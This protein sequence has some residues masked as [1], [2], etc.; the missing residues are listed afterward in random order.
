V[1]EFFV[2]RAGDGDRPPILR[3]IPN[4]SRQYYDDKEVGILGFPPGDSFII[5]VHY[6]DPCVRPTATPARYIHLFDSKTSAW[7]TKR[8]YLE[9]PNTC[10]RTS[11]TKVIT[12]GGMRGSMGWVD[13]CRGIL[14]YNVLRGTDK[15]RYIPLPSLQR[16]QSALEEGLPWT[17]RDITVVHGVIRYFAMYRLAGVDTT[18]DTVGDWHANTWKMKKPWK[19]WQDEFHMKA[20][21]I[22]VDDARRSEL[23][24][25]LAEDNGA[26]VNKPAALTRLRA[27]SPVLSL[28]DDDVVYILTKPMYNKDKAWL[29]AVDMNTKTLRAVDE[30]DTTRPSAD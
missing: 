6:Q 20:S 2:Y 19:K 27:G 7:S 3:M 30:L 4:P 16:Q 12:M 26:E 9:T 28:H 17:V 13:L 5:A 29:I 22:V 23:L 15:V 24:G 25:D 21:E 1:N 10:W 18:D 8:V 11:T 14:V